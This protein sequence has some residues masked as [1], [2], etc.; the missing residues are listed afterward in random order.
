MMVT[1]QFQTFRVATVPSQLDKIQFYQGPS[2]SRPRAISR[3]PRSDIEDLAARSQEQ[4]TPI[5]SVDMN[6]GEHSQS[7]L[8]AIGNGTDNLPLEDF[9]L[10]C[11]FEDEISWLPQANNSIQTL[12]QTPSPMVMTSIRSDRSLHSQ[13]SPSLTDSFALEADEFRNENTPFGQTQHLDNQVSARRVPDDILNTEGRFTHSLSESNGL[14]S[15]SSQAKRKRRRDKNSAHARSEKP[16]PKRLQAIR[17]ARSNTECRPRVTR[18]MEARNSLPSPLEPDQLLEGSTE[19]LSW[20]QN[21]VVIQPLLSGPL[22]AFNMAH[23]T[24]ILRSP[25]DVAA[26]TGAASTTL[27]RSIVGRNGKLEEISLV[28][29]LTNMWLLTGII[30]YSCSFDNQPRGNDTGE[31]DSP[32]E[33]EDD[34][35]SSDEAYSRQASQTESDGRDGIESF[36]TNKE[37]NFVSTKRG[38]WSPT[39]DELLIKLK[40]IEKPWGFIF[41]QFPERSHASVSSRWYVVLRSRVDLS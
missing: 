1:S 18:S 9:D 8:P 19:P 31:R 17:S 13:L 4:G 40:N 14:S 16:R 26:F 41:R 6:P 20:K 15:M 32:R 25:R 28:P 35:A 7:S 27:L 5:E 21:R 36:V 23:L 12:S 3:E 39:E 37:E 11:D 2:A 33:S 22:L 38:R 10:C 34:D 24:A 30:Y 29:V